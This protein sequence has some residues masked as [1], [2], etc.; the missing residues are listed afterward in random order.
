MFWQ[1]LNILYVVAVVLLLFN[2]T[3]FAHELGH[4]LIGRRRGAKIERFAIWF[5]PALWHKTIHG[6]EYRLGCIPFGGYVA[7][8]QLAMESIEGKSETPAEKLEPL[9]PGDKIPIL[10]AGSFANILLGFLVACIVWMV[11]VP[12]EASDFDLIVGYVSANTPEEK[13]G[14]RPG[15]RII[16]INDNPVK[17][18]DEIRQRVALSL[19]Q[20]VRVGLERNGTLQT[21]E[22]VPD[23]DDLFKI[24]MLGFEHVNIPVA[25]MI[26][27]NSPAE[28]A[29]IQ[30]GD[31][32]L[33]VD[34]EKVLGTLHLIEMIGQRAN[35][36]TCLF[37][38][39]NGER[40][41]KVV[42]KKAG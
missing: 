30:P 35:K 16:S 24:R 25:G 21:V 40:I 32:F 28:K 41:G 12:K 20:G 36:P 11:G 34:G 18:W 39:R 31:E 10:F 27:P 23:R 37:L 38:L 5:G 4:Y 13:A 17:D 15:D 7:F 9:K 22:I 2:L 1:F 33:I 26:Q 6:V 8:P 19:T 29:G 42:K 3:I 14:I